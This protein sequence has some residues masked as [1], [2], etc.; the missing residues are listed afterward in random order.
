[1]EEH[2]ELIRVA[3]LPIIEERLRSLKESVDAQAEEA[4][5]LVCTDETVRSVKAVRSGLRKQFD[6]LENQRKA[7]R[8]A[9]FAP[10]DQFEAVYRECVSDAFR[11]ADAALKGKIDAVESEIKRHCED[12]LREYFDELCAAHG[13][14]WLKYEQAGI[15]VDMAS[16]KQKTAKKLRQQA[17]DFVSRV[18]QDAETIAQM[19]DADELMAEYKRRLNL[20]E[21]FSAV[22]DRHRRIEAERRHTEQAA[23][24]KAAAD[25]AVRRAEALAPPTVVE[26]Q[27]SVTFTVTDTKARLIALRELMKANG[28]KYE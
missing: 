11:T 13:I 18:N 20:P 14:D 19:D 15:K 2:N 21:A 12:G 8:A 25:E 9:V 17:A 5:S 24:Q 3:Q 1:M 28:Y 7:V 22:Q 4:L 27:I 16:A 26:E 10:Y 23:A 6:E